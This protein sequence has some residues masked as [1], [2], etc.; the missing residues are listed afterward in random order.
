MLADKLDMTHTNDTNDTSTSDQA[1]AESRGP[2]PIVMQRLIAGIALGIT[3]IVLGSV[4]VPRDTTA[5]LERNGHES[6]TNGQDHDGPHGASDQQTP[7]DLPNAEPAHNDGPPE[8]AWGDVTI[9]MDTA[10]PHEGLPLLGTLEG[11]CYRTM[12]YG[13]EEGP[14]FTVIPVDEPDPIAVLLD[15]RTLTKYFPD[16]PQPTIAANGELKTMY[17]DPSG[18]FPH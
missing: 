15:S 17:V 13:T 6:Q 18:P 5:G 2:S 3:F 9:T 14:R 1:H 16:V 4:F 7:N 11:R 8:E 10:D 12:I